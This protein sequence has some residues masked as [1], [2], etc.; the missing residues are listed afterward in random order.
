MDAHLK[1]DFILII[2]II[3]IIPFTSAQQFVP[4]IQTYSFLRL[5][6]QRNRCPRR[7]RS[8]QHVLIFVIILLLL[9]SRQDTL[10]HVADEKNN[11]IVVVRSFFGL[12]GLP[13]L[14]DPI[15]L[16]PN[17]TNACTQIFIV[18][19]LLSSVLDS[20]FRLPQSCLAVSPVVCSHVSCSSCIQIL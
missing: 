2:I 17:T 10:L 12:N 7:L 4:P 15:C 9:V 5:N 16:G 14:R 1:A 6:R 20:F 13:F 11:R 8:C 18:L 19:H 3:I